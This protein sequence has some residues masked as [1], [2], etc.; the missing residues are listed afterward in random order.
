MPSLLPACAR[1][2]AW[3]VVV[4]A[5]LAAATGCGLISSGSDAS[6]GNEIVA[7]KENRDTE[8]PPVHGGR[9]VVAV[10]AE[11]NGWNPFMN[12]WGDAPTLIGTMMIEPLAI[13]NN[14]GAPQPWLAEKWEPNSDFTEWDIA[15]RPG[16]TF[17]DG[18]PFNAAAAKRSLDKLHQSGLY[19]LQYAPLYEQVEVTGE[20]T[21][22]VHLKVRWAQYPTSLAYAWMLAPAM[23]DRTD[24]GTTNPIGTGPFRFQSWTQFKSLSAIR[25]DGYWRKDRHGQQLPYLDEIEF[26]LINDDVARNEAL[27][28][29]AIDM[30]LS[31]GSDIAERLADDF[32]IIKDYSSQ[33]THIILNTEEAQENEGNPFT[34]IHARR[35]VAYATDRERIAASIGPGV[36]VTTHGFRPDSPWAPARDGYVDYDPAMARK[37]LNLYKKAT[38]ADALRFTLNASGSSDMAPA[39]ETFKKNLAEVGIEVTINTVEPPQSGLLVASG[40]FEAGLVRMHDLPDPDQMNFFYS[41]ETYGPIGDLS[42]NLPR[43][44]SKTLDANLGILRESTDPEMR[45]A[46][47]DDVIRESNEAVTNIW[48]YDTPGS[49]V[50][51]RRVRGLDN[52][53]TYAFIN[54]LPKPW[55]AE[56][57]I[58]SDAG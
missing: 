20:M 6:G 40:T 25:Y 45:K 9:L 28:S 11:S 54:P 14:D 47:S 38:G 15:L 42:L 37:E 36:Q 29:G 35:A 57:S 41:S 43:Y 22:R 8:P 21:V 3:G 51:S 19:S 13:Q 2:G 32:Q 49:I 55:L 12:Q 58:R 44:R 52:F 24:E 50:A 17:H 23:L 46:A 18:S 5:I 1:R 34:S 27:K 30:A 31:S 56:A 4:L 48:L 33:R 7:T 39:V 16:I 26:R 53:R 10:P